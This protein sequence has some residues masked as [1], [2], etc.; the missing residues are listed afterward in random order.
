MGRLMTLR[1]LSKGYTAHGLNAEEVF[2]YE[3]TD[4][5]LGW[6]VISAECVDFIAP[7]VG[8]TDGLILHMTD[9]YKSKF[10]LKDNSIIGMVASYVGEKQ[11]IDPNHIIVESLY[12]SNLDANPTSYLIILEE[13]KIDATHNIIYRIKERSQDWD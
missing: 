4:L 6:K 3:G 9:T 7:I 2:T 8:Q 11:I 13:V 1:G 12:I 5:S 10:N